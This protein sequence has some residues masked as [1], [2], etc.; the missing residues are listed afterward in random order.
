MG[1]FGELKILRSNWLV[2][3]FLESGKAGFPSFWLLVH[4]L[5]STIT[6][7]QNLD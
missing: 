6:A 3:S 4:F 7:S 5:N 2:V 1:L